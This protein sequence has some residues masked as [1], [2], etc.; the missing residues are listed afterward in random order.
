MKELEKLIKCVNELIGEERV[1]LDK[2]YY[3]YRVEMRK[4]YG[5]LF[6]SERGTKKETYLFLQGMLK[7]L[8]LLRSKTSN[9]V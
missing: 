5:T 4:G 3:G 6:L 8:E 7:T 9:D 2:S 1:I